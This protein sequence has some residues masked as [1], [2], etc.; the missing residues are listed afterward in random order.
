MSGASTLIAARSSESTNRRNPEDQDECDAAGPQRIAHR[1]RLPPRHPGAGRREARPVR[2]PVAPPVGAP[3]RR[4]P[5]RPGWRRWRLG[6]R[7][8]RPARSV[9]ANRVTRAPNAL[10]GFSALRRR[11]TWR[12]TP[13][14]FVGDS[15]PLP[16]RRRAGCAETLDRGDE[17]AL[18][19][20]WPCR[21]CRPAC[22]R[23]LGTRYRRPR[24]TRT[25]RIPGWY[26]SPL[27]S[28]TILLHC[29]SRSGD[30]SLN[31]KPMPT[32][33]SRSLF[34]ESKN[35]RTVSVVWFPSSSHFGW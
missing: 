12:S 16:G 28:V 24:R 27:R 30:G 31:P 2:L 34:T 13:S 5:S 32:E 7:A 8:G 29:R 1:H 17:R 18:V 11:G 10:T 22:C 26:T 15:V 19:R 33:P 3:P 25:R 23:R 6:G 9:D 20:A 21:S 4:E 14:C 35:L